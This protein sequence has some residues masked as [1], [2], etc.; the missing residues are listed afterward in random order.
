M[1][2]NPLHCLKYPIKMNFDDVII[3]KILKYFI[4]GQLDMGLR[5]C[6]EKS[7]YYGKYSSSI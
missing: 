5:L 4:R 1:K 3:L 6:S 2:K 7:C